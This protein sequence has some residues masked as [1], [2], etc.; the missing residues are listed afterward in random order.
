MPKLTEAHIPLLA[1]LIPSGHRGLLGMHDPKFRPILDAMF[2]EG[3][4]DP[5]RRIQNEMIIDR[6]ADFSRKA[7]IAAANAQLADL[8]PNIRDMVRIDRNG[9]VLPLT[10]GETISRGIRAFRAAEAG[11]EVAREGSIAGNLLRGVVGGATEA[12][13]NLIDFN[14]PFSDYNIRDSLEKALGVH[15]F[16]ENFRAQFRGTTIPVQSEEGVELKSFGGFAGQDAPLSA[17][18]GAGIG[19]LIP[20]M[21]VAKAAGGALT[22][23]AIAGGLTSGRDH[24][25][26]GGVFGAA[27]FGAGLLGTNVIG[28]RIAGGLT[29]VA[30]NLGAAGLSRQA[31]ARIFDTVIPEISK[32]AGEFMAFS[33]LGAGEQLLHSGGDFEALSARQLLGVNLGMILLMR[34]GHVAQLASAN[35]AH[36]VGVRN[37]FL[38]RPRTEQLRVTK[39]RGRGV[40]LLRAGGPDRLLELE[41]AFRETG[42]AFGSKDSPMLLRAPSPIHSRIARVLAERPEGGSLRT[43]PE[44]VPSPTGVKAGPE[45]Q[46]VGAG[47]VPPRIGPGPRPPTQFEGYLAEVTRIL[48]EGKVE[49]T[50]E[51][52]ERIAN[53]PLQALRVIAK[54]NPHL[55]TDSLF[56]RAV[57][58][59]TEMERLG[60][61][62]DLNPMRDVAVVEGK[63]S[64]P[65]IDKLVD[66]LGELR[67]RAPTPEVG[68]GI[69]Q[70]MDAVKAL[71][72][73][74][75]AVGVR[76]HK[77]A[78]AARLSEQAAKLHAS[79]PDSPEARRMLERA[80]LAM[81]Q[82][83]EAPTLQEA[84]RA[85][86]G[87][88]R[89]IAEQLG[90]QARETQALLEA[91]TQLE[92]RASL[93]PALEARAAHL[94]NIEVT[95]EGSRRRLQELQSALQRVERPSKAL[96]QE[97]E[98]ALETIDQLD[99]EIRALR[100]RAEA[101]ENLLP[102]AAELTRLR[103]LQ[104]T[105]SR[106]IRQAEKFIDLSR[107]QADAVRQ[108]EKTPDQEPV[109]PDV[110]E[111]RADGLEQGVAQ[112][113]N[114]VA[115]RAFEISQLERRLG[116][117]PGESAESL[118]PP[119][120]VLRPQAPVLEKVKAGHYKGGEFE[121]RKAGRRWELTESG[122]LVGDFPTLK[123]AREAVDR[124]VGE[125]EGVP[126]SAL[127]G[128]RAELAE[129]VR[130]LEQFR[131]RQQTIEALERRILEL[132]RE[133]VRANTERRAIEQEL[134]RQEAAQ[135]EEV[136]FQSQA[137]M[138]KFT[139][140]MQRELT[141][142]YP[143]DELGPTGK[144]IL[145]RIMGAF[146]RAEARK[147]GVGGRTDEH[148]PTP[149][150]NPSGDVDTSSRPMRAPERTD[151]PGTKAA[152]T[153]VEEAGAA[154]DP[155]I[156]E[157]G[158]QGKWVLKPEARKR[159]ADWTKKL[160]K[161]IRGGRQGD[162]PRTPKGF[163]SKD[164]TL[165][166]LHAEFRRAYGEAIDSVEVADNAAAGLV[167]PGTKA[168]RILRNAE[169]EVVLEVLKIIREKAQ[170][171]TP[172]VEINLRRGERGHALNFFAPARPDLP[173]G[174]SPFVVKEID[175]LTDTIRLRR[176]SD[177]ISDEISRMI[178]PG[179]HPGEGDRAA[180]AGHGVSWHPARV[181]DKVFS[182]L[183]VIRKIV[184]AP[185]LD[186][187]VHF[188]A[189]ARDRAAIR[190]DHV[191]QWITHYIEIPLAKLLKAQPTDAARTQ[192]MERLFEARLEG[193][194]APE[195]L[196]A[197][198][199]TV[200]H[201]LQKFFQ[202]YRPA[203]EF[204]GIP[205]KSEK[206]YFP[207]IRKVMEKFGQMRSDE[208]GE[209][210]LKGE[211][212]LEAAQ[213]ERAL[214][215]V[216]SGRLK[217]RMSEDPEGAIRD[218]LMA[219]RAYASSVERFLAWRPVQDVITNMARYYGV[220][221]SKAFRGTK[222]ARE[223]GL[224]KIPESTFW[225]FRQQVKI[226]N[227]VGG[228]VSK[229]IEATAEGIVK[230]MGPALKL[231]GI[232]NTEGVTGRFLVG[233]FIGAI[234]VGALGM[235]I[236]SAIKNLTQN[237]FTIAEIGPRYWVRGVRGLYQRTSDGRLIF[238]PLLERLGVF[239]AS[240]VK[241]LDNDI[242]ALLR[243]NVGLF[244]GAAKT[245]VFGRELTDAM[246]FF[247]RRGEF[248]N[249]GV[250]AIGTY[251]K[252][253]D[254]LKPMIERGVL[255]K[256]AAAKQAE[257]AARMV[258]DRTQFDFSRMTGGQAFSG[259]AGRLFG[260]FTRFNINSWDYLQMLFRR[261]VGSKE[262]RM[263][264]QERM[265]LLPGESAM[266]P[267]L[268]YIASSLALGYLGMS[269]VGISI[270]DVEGPAAVVPG[271][272]KSAVSSVADVGARGAAALGVGNEFR[273]RTG[274]RRVLSTVGLSTRDR[275]P[276]Q[277]L[278]AS[279]G[280]AVG[281]SW[282]VATAAVGGFDKKSTEDL[283]DSLVPVMGAFKVPGVAVKRVVRAFNRE[284][285]GVIR[286]SRTGNRIF[287]EEGGLEW[288]DRFLRMVGLQTSEEAEA[289]DELGETLFERR[290]WDVKVA[291]I[292]QESIDRLMD[293]H[294]PEDV[295]GFHLA[296]HAQ[297]AEEYD[298]FMTNE[299][300][301]KEI[302]HIIGKW[303]EVRDVS[304]LAREKKKVPFSR[305][306]DTG[307]VNTD[308]FGL[309][310]E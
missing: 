160:Q 141:A 167:G 205:L 69:G 6:A 7:R 49:V 13:S 249:R 33:V 199:V 222:Q 53:N 18:I 37:R 272:V 74:V 246:M 220:E 275:T 235:N 204:Y 42:I 256:E 102:L 12:G 173:K 133:Q 38:L 16:N 46:R 61:I 277:L 190:R 1:D 231:V 51:I 108:M 80:Q 230:R 111:R 291:E 35:A 228:S 298:V 104:E 237:V 225:W 90:P 152:E 305:R 43:P 285:D 301:K 96:R 92:L 171:I 211:A 253:M 158:P 308:A 147:S 8:P 23:F 94:R 47:E 288:S 207:M 150:K 302:K 206:T 216:G 201:N 120:P 72:R 4:S 70:T 215:S 85:K 161:W 29:R 278:L 24:R 25:V 187:F 208:V 2:I 242:H 15:A 21:R 245:G 105:A 136:V 186:R 233:G 294:S 129:Q 36:A 20:F 243:P 19:H 255:T 32:I 260:Q 113:R 267:L 117:D 227:G 198:G 182:S 34:A 159:V 99:V 60:L 89:S 153:T 296:A 295:I 221:G 40:D 95:Y 106:Q 195:G 196:P 137:A 97:L 59:A 88:L 264:A 116:L 157:P 68:V 241:S 154:P 103:A 55:L 100:G 41:V 232:K 27:A 125:S 209:A 10:D 244:R 83:R 17:S 45:T 145:A 250:A 139:S 78:E 293:G 219:T 292:R 77:M 39:A 274:T 310:G 168:Q 279:T 62:A 163:K 174:R 110:L 87:E 180:G 30:Q 299:D 197:E 164:G 172:E 9:E 14:I 91:A 290:L 131:D 138:R 71:E 306:V 73:P 261:A 98:R 236:A 124:R 218:V 282:S 263:R 214:E 303:H 248:F 175:P 31:Q 156:M 67:L 188:F 126:L 148:N 56:E 121:V 185:W 200:L 297:M 11:A 239:S 57:Q 118:R 75:V 5:V 280:P 44:P 165:G 170:M 289:R 177:A 101:T 240:F 184:R 123:A 149:P 76:E 66:S 194:L 178:P 247:F 58:R 189:E 79:N 107:S 166:R 22:G 119:E 193:N 146:K 257:Q 238:N 115:A 229:T 143:Y 82:A 109:N 212:P 155:A 309:F 183:N 202:M 254:S 26:T 259:S 114:E 63:A 304:V 86:A 130:P 283:L 162:M 48:A 81:Q 151:R 52:A 93:N 262:S 217:K 203:L 268:R 307:E 300:Y 135:P 134:A 276:G 269:A 210:L 224:P 176:E 84:L 122:E 281:I 50:P 270:D 127:E 191:N 266:A 252:V 265:P 54:D 258:V 213:T 251:H 65:E 286:S 284:R 179:S 112:L 28:T 287:P 64:L 234:H 144:E 169:P 226:F 273:N 142:R 181:Y 223:L 140:E 132:G 271:F 128:Q 192:I 3:E